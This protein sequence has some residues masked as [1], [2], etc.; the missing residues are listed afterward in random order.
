MLFCYQGFCESRR[1]FVDMALEWH[2]E[3]GKLD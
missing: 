2:V 3:K 1:D